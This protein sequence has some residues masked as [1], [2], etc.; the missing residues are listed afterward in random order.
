MSVYPV[1]N[2]TPSNLMQTLNSILSFHIGHFVDIQMS[3]FG[4]FPKSQN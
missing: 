3:L 1:P 4:G 2:G